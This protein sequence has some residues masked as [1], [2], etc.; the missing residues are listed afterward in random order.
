MSSTFYIV[1]HEFKVGKAEKWW[2][3]AHAAMAPGGRWDDTVTVNKEKGFF[4]H[5]ANAVTKNGL[6][7][8]FW[9]VKKRISAEEFQEFIDGPYGPGFGQ[10]AL[11][12]ICKPID[13]FLMNGQ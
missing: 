8:C 3:T 11:M 2:E 7:Y 5:S 9:E 4:N 1:H 10:D 12:N 13:T 6:L